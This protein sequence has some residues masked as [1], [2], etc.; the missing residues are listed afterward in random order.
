MQSENEST[1]DTRPPR[2][3]YV[4][5][6]VIFIPVVILTNFTMLVIAASDRYQLAALI[7][8]LLGPFLNIIFASIGLIA[9]RIFLRRE[10]FSTAFHLAM[11]L[12]LPFIATLFNAVLILRSIS[13]SLC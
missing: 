9:W 2:L 8:V 3:N 11:I 7:A 12:G 10:N 4:W 5:F 1:V 13:G 6:P